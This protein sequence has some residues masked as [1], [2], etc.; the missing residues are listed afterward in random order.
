MPYSKSMSDIDGGSIWGD[1]GKALVPIAVDA[2]SNALK[3]YLGS[4]MPG[5][6]HSGIRTMGTS[7]MPIA[8]AETIQLGSPYQQNSSPAMNPFIPTHNQYGGYAPITKTIA[9]GSFLPGGTGFLPAGTHG[10]SFLP[11]GGSGG[12][13]MGSRAMRRRHKRGEGF[14]W[15]NLASTALSLA[16]LLL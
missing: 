5:A 4:G 12:G 15:G 9:G 10:G 6:N 2:G 13:V 14:D 1:V 7:I 3:N 16:P 11:S 8:T